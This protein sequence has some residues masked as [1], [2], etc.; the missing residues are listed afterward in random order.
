[1]D[2]DYLPVLR[3]S[4]GPMS[5][6]AAADRA[7][8]AGSHP[9]ASH[10]GIVRRYRNSTGSVCASRHPRK[11]RRQKIPRKRKPP[12]SGIWKSARTLPT[13]KR[14]IFKSCLNT[15]RAN[16]YSGGS[17]SA[18]L[19]RRRS[20]R[21]LVDLAANS[22]PERGE[23]LGEEPPLAVPALARIKTGQSRRLN[24]RS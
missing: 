2:S 8:H 22:R 11:P 4:T 10:N 12:R 13:L 17:R 6:D 15:P 24:V 3:P 21:V 5:V 14:N 1:M 19:G 18:R 16:K 9:L 23:G 7:N 20:R